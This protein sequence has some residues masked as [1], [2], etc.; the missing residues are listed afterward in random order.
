[1]RMKYL[2]KKEGD[3]E[4]TNSAQGLNVNSSSKNYLSFPKLHKKNKAI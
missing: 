2:Y 1:M 3:R 4:K